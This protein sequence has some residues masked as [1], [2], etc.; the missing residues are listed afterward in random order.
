MSTFSNI[1]RQLGGLILA[2]LS[3]TGGLGVGLGDAAGQAFSVDER[4]TNASVAAVCDVAVMIGGSTLP[5]HH[6]IAASGLPSLTLSVN[7]PQVQVGDELI[8]TATIT[9]GLGPWV[10]DAYLALLLPDGTLVFLQGDGG[11]TLEMKPFVTG[12][13]AVPVQAAIFRYRFTGGEMAGDYVWLA[14]FTVSGTTAI[15]GDIAQ[16]PFTFGG[17]LF[18]DD[19]TDGSVDGWSMVAGQWSVVDGELVETSDS[20]THSIALGGPDLVDFQLTAQLRSTDDD[21][22]GLVF[23]FYDNNNFYVAVLNDEKD[24]IEVRKRTGGEFS[25][26]AR[27]AANPSIKGIPVELGIRVA[28]ARLQVFLNGRTVI[29]IDVPE[30]SRGRVGLYARHNKYAAFDNIRMLTLNALK[31]IGGNVIYV[32][33]RNAGG[34]E[35][36]LTEATAW[37]SI[38]AALEDPRFQKSAGNTILIKEGVYYEQ[39]NVLGRMSGIPGGFNTI[40]AAAGAAVVIDGEKNTPNA[41]VEGMLI[42]SGVSYVR[43]ESLTIR[44][45][46]HRGILVFDSGPGE[47]RGNLIHSCGDTGLEFWFGAQ[48]YDVAY[49]VIYRN[50]GD[51]IVLNQGSG[52]DPSRFGANQGIVIR[53][54][55]ILENG[56]DGGDG[57]RVDGDQPHTFALHNNTIVS[58]ISNGIFI[59]LGVKAGSIKNNIVVQNGR[60]GLKNFANIPSDFNNLFANGTTGDKNYDDLPPHEDPG[61]N[62]ISANPLFVNPAAWDYRLQVGSP[63][64]NTGDPDPQFSDPDGTRND[65]G[66][67]GG[68]VDLVV[69]PLL[70]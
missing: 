55:L 1:T 62:T 31:P 44:N 61:P 34:I 22:I 59:N 29:E 11:I 6:A 69:V 14:A 32:D 39:V 24:R 42:H 40:R 60:I 20:A 46:Q 53:N 35:N 10:V 68:P 38:S 27:V 16:A 23:R 57:I 26:L 21:D 30:V 33:G 37:G 66:V 3:L 19:F 8:L 18:S 52:E 5:T 15:L 48:H 70:E 49:N 43:I 63:S 65:M 54:N 58:N 45:A 13:S 67:F 36:G 2:L 9:P 7:H 12:W 50:E 64:I 41:R 51:G 17:E 56:P 28:Q 4:M 47:I 25:T